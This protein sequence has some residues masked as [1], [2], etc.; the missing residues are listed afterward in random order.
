[1]LNIL[2]VF[3]NTYVS[4]FLVMVPF[5]LLETCNFIPISLLWP[6]IRHCKYLK[7]WFLTV[8]LLYSLNYTFECYC[9]KFKKCSF[10][11]YIY[12]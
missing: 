2:T 12:L 4:K 3:V 6:E 7:G 10:S 5:I 8:I 11:F 9:W 1:M